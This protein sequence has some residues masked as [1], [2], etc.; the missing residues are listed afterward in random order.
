MSRLSVPP[1]DHRSTQLSST[2]F[3]RIARAIKFAEKSR[4]RVRVGAVVSS[5]KRL[6]GAAN[7]NRNS[8]AINHLEASV[9]AEVGALRRMTVG[10][11]GSSVYVAR[12]GAR[13]RLLP[14]FPCSRCLSALVACRVK[15]VVWWDGSKWCA[16][17]VSQI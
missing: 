14:S 8:P 4:H 7:K 3:A 10:T 6:S 5:G 15:R 2:D 11:A 12:L 17:K 16:T 1:P 13:G 9:H